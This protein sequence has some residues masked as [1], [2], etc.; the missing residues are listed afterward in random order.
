MDVGALLRSVDA[1]AA[2]SGKSSPEQR[3]AGAAEQHQLVAGRLGM[4]SAL[5]TSLRC[6]H[7]PT[8]DHS[9]RVALGCSAW[10]AALQ[11]PDK[12]RTQLEAAALL[13]DVGKIGVPDSILNK[14]GRL[15]DIELEII[16]SSREASRHILHSSGAP[17]EI[18]DGVVSASAW[19][20]GSHRS[21]TL[22]GDQT[23]FVS[24]MIA[25]VDAFDSMTTDQVYRPARSRDQAIATLYEQAG[26]QFDPDLVRSYCELFSHDQRQLEADVAA[27]WLTSATT[28]SLPW[29]A[30]P[31]PAEA[32]SEGSTPPSEPDLFTTRLVEN[33]HDAVMFLDSQRIITMWNSGAEKLTGVG[34][35]AAIGKEMTPSLLDMAAATGELIDEAACPIKK[36]LGEGMQALERVSVMGRNGQSVTVDMHVIP[37]S[38][39]GRPGHFVGATVLMH[40][41]S[42]EATLEE[43]CQALHAEM[44]KDP[45]TQVA[46][47]AEF[48]RMLAAFVEA[49]LDTELRCSLI[50]ADIDRFKSINDTYGHQ[51]GDEAIMT[52][53]G[54]MK[55]MCRTGDLVARYGGEEFAILCA[56]CNNATAAKRADAIRKKLSETPHTNLGGRTITASF[57]VTELQPGDTPETLLRRS[58]RALLQAKDQGRNQVVQLGGGMQTENQPKAGWGGIGKWLLG[59]IG[60]G[61]GAIVQTRLVTNVP[62]ELTVEKLRGFIADRDAEIVKTSENYIRLITEE[63]DGSGSR[64]G[65]DQPI[66][67]I[68]DIHLSQVHIERTNNVGL[69]A[70]KYVHTY[71]DVKIQPRRDRDRSK[72]KIVDRARKLLSSLQA[73]L[74][75]REAVAEPTTV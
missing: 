71:V 20:D 39:T 47:R 73:Y 7:P 42:S 69:A 30:T 32:A 43:R 35:T 6:K 21:V 60:G 19:F 46:N 18:I 72:A 57:G 22:T 74:M 62:I 64:R 52:F 26:T 8:A 56:D 1:A 31:R 3:A 59:S 11:M 5:F 63:A 49:H 23:P 36:S 17:D 2:V 40:D 41:V 14:T 44:I 9:L 33:M 4:A 15:S 70:G 58:D 16:D 53:A 75:A 29:K 25:I 13:H 61:N 65:S 66:S 55:S 28:T 38:A 24:R 67:F 10:A 51:A 34:A 50:M 48:D 45:M 68:V 27:R 37:V 12:L 54:L